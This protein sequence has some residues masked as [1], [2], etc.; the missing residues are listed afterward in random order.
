MNKIWIVSCKTR[1]QIV[2]ECILNNYYLN[3]KSQYLITTHFDSINDLT[4]LNDKKDNLQKDLG[5]KY[6]IGFINSIISKS[7]D[8]C[9]FN[10]FSLST[11]RFV[12][13]YEFTELLKVISHGCKNPN[14]LKTRDSKYFSDW[15]NRFHCPSGIPRIEYLRFQRKQKRDKLKLEKE[16]RK[17]NE[18]NL[19][20]F[21][22]NQKTNIGKL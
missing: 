18:K 12:G 4:I 1:K 5:K 10:L 15:V 8:N 20:R 3:H 2:D 22:Q 17:Q 14:P 19:E 6:G 13:S 9:K 16:K 21:R 11:R 7:I